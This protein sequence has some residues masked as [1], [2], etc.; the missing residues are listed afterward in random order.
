MSAPSEVP[1]RVVTKSV[2]LDGVLM[3]VEERIVDSMHT[4]ILTPR[5]VSARLDSLVTHSCSVCPLL[6]PP[7]A[8]LDVERTVTVNTTRQTDVLVTK[9]LLEILTLDV[10]AW[11]N[12]LAQVYNVDQMLL[13]QCQLE[14][15]SVS[16]AK[17]ILETPTVDVM[18]LM[19]AQPMCVV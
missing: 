5:L 9:A 13:A 7:F 10:R 6:G 15:P 16:A 18:T 4:A 8:H 14:Y 17:A 1:A 19:S 3:L 2:N 12:K 11:N